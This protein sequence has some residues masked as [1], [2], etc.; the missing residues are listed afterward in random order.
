MYMIDSQKLKRK[1]FK[2]IAVHLPKIHYYARRIVG[3]DLY[4]FTYELALEKGK[5][6]AKF[7]NNQFLKYAISTNFSVPRKK[8]LKKSKNPLINS[9]LGK[10]EKYEI[11]IHSQA[12]K[13]FKFRYQ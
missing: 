5:R 1:I 13:I 2:V 8:P 6:C 3:V 10:I 11:V 12:Q 7:C 9:L 4:N